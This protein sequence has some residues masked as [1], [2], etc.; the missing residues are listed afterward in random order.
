MILLDTN[1][2]S[3]LMRPM[4]NSKVV[5]WL[6]DQPETDIWISVEDAQ[7]AAIALTADLTLATRNVKD[8]FEIDKLQIINPWEM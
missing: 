6:D 4:P 8:F 5:F 7:I 3:E 2:I 1:I